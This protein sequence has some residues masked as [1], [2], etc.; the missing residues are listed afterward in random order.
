MQTLVHRWLGS[1]MIVALTSAAPAQEPAPPRNPVDLPLASTLYDVWLARDLPLEELRDRAVRGFIDID[2]AR[3]VEVELVGPRGGSAAPDGLVRAFGG[4]PGARYRNLLDAAVPLERLVDLARA[5]PAGHFVRPT[6]RPVP[7]D[8]AGEG[9]VWMGSAAWRNGGADGTGKTIAV[10]DGDFL[11]LDAAVANGDIG[12][13]HATNYSGEPLHFA[14]THGTA[15][16]EIVR[17]HAPGAT[18]RLYK[19]KTRAQLGL[20]VADCIAQGV[21]VISHSLGWYGDFWFDDDGVATQ[22]V[23][24]ACDAGI[25][26]VSAAG[27]DAQKHWQGTFSESASSPGWHDWAPGD[28][29]L[30][31]LISPNTTS[32][33][34]LTW[35]TGGSDNDNH[36]L[37]V[38]D[39]NGT[40]LLTSS[41]NGGENFESVAWTN[42]HPTLGLMVS[43]GVRRLSGSGGE[44][45]LFAT[46][47]SNW[48]Y[49]VSASSTASP[50]NCT[51]GN[52]LSVGAVPGSEYASPP[53]SG[54]IAA[55]Y[56]S[57][58]PTN[59]GAL[60]PHVAGPTNTSTFSAG[61][62]TGTSCA[63]PN[64]AGLMACLGSSVPAY[65]ESAI[66]WLTK[67]HASVFKDWSSAGQ[68][69]V[70]GHGGANLIDFAP[71]TRWL[72]NEYGNASGSV[73]RPANTLAHALLQTPVG[74][75]IVA[76]PGGNYPA[77]ILLTK[78]VTLVSRGADALCGD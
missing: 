19:I 70:Y 34:S 17:D 74:G 51:H 71:H 11:G 26:F 39:I 64:V 58:G 48:E 5:L 37:F 52:F 14:D 32:W 77:P 29:F 65:N 9:P 75:R 57:R 24:Q 13:W 61:E 66:A 7:R 42:N 68:D 38:Y 36:D 8:V 47:T 25:L 60:R 4:E 27:N 69:N 2:D 40:T 21:D 72:T 45:E 20:A 6:L 12:A 55:D 49:M 1:T 59:G 73:S 53:G 43:I 16:A 15:C 56:S 44:F 30:Q 46:G 10:I 31:L 41:T 33:F 3:S 62:F 50:E 76:F 67:R 78:P 35:N 54:G 63:A 23:E 28:R 22:A 18:L